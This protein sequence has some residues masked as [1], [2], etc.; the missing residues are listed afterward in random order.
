MSSGAYIDRMVDGR[1]QVCGELSFVSVPGLLER[2]KEVFESIEEDRLLRVDLAGVPRA[3]SAG[4]ALLV[5]WVRQARRRN[6]RIEF[7]N[8]PEQMLKIAD[9]SGLRSILPLTGSCQ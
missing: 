7:C 6:I 3:D 1:W 5:C 2:S 4:L 8:V 9:V